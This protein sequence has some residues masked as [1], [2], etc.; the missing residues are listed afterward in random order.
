MQAWLFRLALVCLFVPIPRLGLPLSLENAAYLGFMALWATQAGIV[1]VRVPRVVRMLGILTLVFMAWQF[2]VKAYFLGEGLWA[3]MLVRRALLLVMAC[4]TIR[5]RRDLH[6][7]AAFIVGSML[8]S[9]LV[10]ICTVFDVGPV[11][12]LFGR[13]VECAAQE[14]DRAEEMADLA[15]KR[16]MGLRG[17]VFGFSYLTAPAFLL[18]CAFL[19]RAWRDRNV[20]RMVACYAG[21]AA[22]LLCMA[23]NAERSSFLALGAGLIL[24]LWSL[25]LPGLTALTI[26]PLIGGVALL[27]AVNE[28][29]IYHQE[30]E[31]NNLLQR[32]DHQDSGEFMARAGLAVAG[33]LTVLDHPVSGGSEEDY[34]EKAGSLE[35]VRRFHMSRGELPASHNSYVNAGMRAGVAGWVMLG[36][37]LV[38]VWRMAPVGRVASG[39]W[40]TQD[41]VA[42][43]LRAAF[44]A[45]LVN[46]I[47]H[48]QGIVSGEP[49]TWSVIVLAAGATTLIG[50][51]RASTA[52]PLARRT[53]GWGV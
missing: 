17:S 7:A 36:A 2:V 46:A 25:R 24:M 35:A 32:I 28:V 1:K 8:F 11:V 19:A 49:M 6:L 14:A 38:A 26:G 18:L 47:F 15:A 53:A 22:V 48:N 3:P 5:T 23:L 30:Q 43:S 37:M 10:G 39:P 34:Q 21:M 13:F 12:S 41:P 50:H 29:L 44:L 20:G 31:Q 42:L 9:G 51:E 40:T 4:H 33:A 45:C 52:R 16:L 27:V